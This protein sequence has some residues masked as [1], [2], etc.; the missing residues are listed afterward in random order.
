M[1]DIIRCRLHYE[2]SNDVDSNIY[3]L[4]PLCAM[5]TI[6]S[7]VKYLDYYVHQNWFYLMQRAPL[8]YLIMTLSSA[9]KHLCF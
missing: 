7:C 2:H 1:Q 6:P 9:S 8:R 5:V 3:V 4:R